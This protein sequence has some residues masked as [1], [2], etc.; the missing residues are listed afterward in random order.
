MKGPETP[1]HLFLECSFTSV[2]YAM[3]ANELGVEWG[4]PDSLMERFNDRGSLV[5]GHKRLYGDML[6]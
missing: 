5:Q 4:P 6:L 2:F 3:F 1:N